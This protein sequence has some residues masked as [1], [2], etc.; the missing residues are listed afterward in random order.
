MADSFHTFLFKSVLV[1]LPMI[2]S[3]GVVAV[4]VHQLLHNS[5]VHIKYALNELTKTT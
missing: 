3:L 2:K 1:C 5:L 4:I